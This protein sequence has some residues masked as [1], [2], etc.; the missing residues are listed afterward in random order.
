MQW[1]NT[2]RDKLIEVRDKEKVDW[3][4]ADIDKVIS[5]LEPPPS[6]MN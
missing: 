5:E 4:R 6:E 3:L 2:V 1:F